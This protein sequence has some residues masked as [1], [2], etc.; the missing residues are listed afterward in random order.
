MKSLEQISMT[1][2]LAIAV[3]TLVAAVAHDPQSQTADHWS[4]VTPSRPDQPPN[5][6]HDW[7]RSPVDAFVLAR[8]ES[9]GL[10]PSPEADRRTLIRRVTLDLTGLPPTPGEIESF[11]D[12]Q[13]SDAYER[14][15]DRLLESPHYGERMALRWLDL[16]RYADTNGYSIDGGRHMWAWRE[17]VIDAFNQNMPFDQFTIEQLAGDLLPDATLGQRIASG[18]N[19]NHMNTHEGGTIAEEYRVAYV[20]DR[21]KTT[22]QTWMGLTLGCAQCHDHKYDPISQRDYY[23]FYAFFN[24][25]TDRGNDGNAGVNSVPFIPVYSDEQTEQLATINAT[26]A[27]LDTQL[28]AP[29]PE[30]DVAQDAWEQDLLSN[31]IE[32]PELSLWSMQGPHAAASGNDAFSTAFGPELPEYAEK[33]GDPAWTDQPQF[34][35]GT[36]HSLSGERSAW[37]LRR[38]IMTA[39]AVTVDLSMGSDDA[40]KVWLNGEIVLDNNTRR[41]V[42]P[43]QERLTIDLD[44]GENVI[45]MK[46]VNDGGPGGFYF[47]MLRSGPPEA[48]LA[49]IAIP[50]ADR[51]PDQSAAIRSHFRSIASELEP[52]REQLASQRE[53]ADA[54]V[55]MPLTTVMVMEEMSMPRETFMLERGQYDK[56]GEKVTPGT[57]AVLPPLPDDETPNRLGLARW[58]VDPAH[59]LT[60][61]VAVNGFWQQLFGVGLVKT[62]EDFGIQGEMPSHPELLDWLAVDFV[63]TGWDVKAFMRMLVTSSTYRQDSSVSDA[64]R[65][66]DPE[67][68]LLA[69]GPRFRLEA[70]IIRDIALH[71][72]G[73]MVDRL[74]G[75]S[76]RPYQPPGLWEEMSHF[77]STPATEQIYRVD[78]GEG[79]YRRS[80][81][82]IWKRTVPPPLLVTFDAPNRELCISRR[83]RTN[84]PLQALILLNEVGFV[85]AS[86]GMAERMIKEGGTT[87][88]SRLR[89]GFLLV[90]AREPSE[91]EFA[92][93]EAAYQREL[94]FFQDHIDDAEALLSVGESERDQSIDTPTHAAMTS[95][96]NLL[97]NLSE[98]IT[99]G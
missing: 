68:R 75:P 5:L 86:R 49:A 77:G 19:R 59:P 23:R 54:I 76:A 47:K 79:L 82:T 71:A 60:A 93:L 30:L 48:V 4:F 69:R 36:P 44:A 53:Q 15:V 26:I 78:T 99:K 14:V 40:I 32:T 8:L 17:W 74:G 46:I 13:S 70:E 94:S 67:N 62:S 39:R 81:Y 43:D 80:L 65:A 61:R 27:Q 42:A 84:T 11:L 92:I 38:T 9:E 45:L 24:T 58:M 55:A 37:Y 90:T 21:V 18:F 64:L 35:D 73:L 31:P 83:A 95:I 33:N 63:E 41:G 57:P 10:T 2:F 22:A 3:L 28:L 1:T 29:N 72:G 6:E 12:D 87:H 56:Q 20:A 88:D 89:Y 16:A 91:D 66:L 85:E 51:T 98:T 96:A 34:V 50:A 7:V 25:I 52:I 97:L